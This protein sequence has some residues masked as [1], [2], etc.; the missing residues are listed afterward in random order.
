MNVDIDKKIDNWKEQVLDLT[1][2]N[3]MVDFSAT[4]TKSLPTKQTEWK[5]VADQ[6]ATGN[7]LYVWRPNDEEFQSELDSTDE[8][9][10][11][12]IEDTE[13]ADAQPSTGRTD[14]EASYPNSDLI[15]IRNPKET[16]NSLYNISLNQRK[17]LQEKGV[18]SLY[19]ALGMLEWFSVDY[20]DT[21]L[22]SPVFLV[23]VS[24]ERE[25]ISNPNRHDYKITS[26]DEV[27]INPALR[28]KLKTE[29]GLVL[30]ADTTVELTDLE[31]SFEDIEDLIEGRSRWSLANEVILGIFDFAKLSLYNDLE[32]QR[33]TIKS[34][35]IIRA[36]NGDTSDLNAD[37]SSVP[38]AEELDTTV[39]PIDTFQV[40]EADSSQQEA[41]EAAKQ[42]VSF[43]LQGPPGTGK[44]QTIAN[45]IAEKLAD[46][47]QV[48]FVSEKQAALEVVQNRLGDAGLARFCLPAHGKHASK[49]DVLRALGEELNAPQIKESST[50]P[51][52]LGK[53]RKRR[54]ELNEYG[55]VL[56]RK[57]GGIETSA[58][59]AH[60]IV[61]NLNDVQT[62]SWS[63]SDPL[64]IST[65]EL[66]T[67]IDT[68]D[69]LAQYDTQFR[70]HSS[71]PWS[72]TT[73]DRWRIDT[74]DKMRESL[75]NQLEILDRI[76]SFCE[77]AE[78]KLRITITSLQEFKDTIELLE[79]L[80]SR[81]DIQWTEELFATKFYQNESRLQDFADTSQE[82]ATL[83]EE[84]DKNYE[85][86]VY[87]EDGQELHSAVAAY[88]L[89]R[90]VRPSYWQL[91]K[92]IGAHTVGSYSPSA[93]DLQ[94]DMQQLMVIQQRKDEIDELQDLTR[95]FRQLYEG[96]ETNWELVLEVRE[97]ID[98]LLSESLL[99]EGQV[100]RILQDD[101]TDTAQLL[102]EARSLNQ[103]WKQ[104][105]AFFE[106][107]VDRTSLTTS[108]GEALD[109]ADFDSFSSKLHA[110]ENRVPELQQW[111][112]FS[113][114][115]DSATETIV[116]DYIESALEGDID[117]SYLV[118]GFRKKFY[119]DFLNA[120]YDQ[121]SLSHFNSSQHEK[122]LEQFRQLDKE[123]Q[124]LAKVEIQHR[125]TQRRPTIDL[126]HASSSE[127]VVLR[128]EIEKQ[129]RRMPL[130]ELFSEAGNMITR[131]KP[132]FMM[133]PLSVA[134]HL[135]TDS[136]DF[137]VVIF[138]EASQIMPQDA[139]SS[140]IRAKQ[141]VV[142]G[143][144]KQLPPTQFF[145]GDTETDSDVRDDLESILDE[146]AAVLP[147]KHLRWHYRSR[148]DELIT[149]SNQR[150][151]SGRLN[152]FPENDPDVPTGVDFEFVEDGIYDRGGSRQNQPEAR[153]IVDYIRQFAKE[154][155]SRS[156]GVVAFSEAQERA[157]RDLIEE[158]RRDDPVL[159]SF[160]DE[161][162]ALEG[163][164]IKNL[165]A[166]QGDERDV[167]LFSVGYGPDQSGKI[168]MNFGPLN[169]DGG[170]RRLNVAITRARERVIVFS[171]LQPGDIDTTRTE[172][173][174][175]RDFKAY[176]EYAK[177][178]KRALLE[179]RQ[180]TE[181]LNF[182]SSFEESVYTALEE[183]GYDVV[184]QVRSSG[185]S[186][187]LAIKHPE[188]PGKYILGIECDGAAYHSSKTARDRDRTRQLIL[189][190]LGWTIHR[191]WSP[192]WASNREQVLQS[193]ADKVSKLRETGRITEE[194]PV[195]APVK[196]EEA[197]PVES[198][199]QDGG[200]PLF[201]EYSAP[202]VQTY[203]DRDFDDIPRRTLGNDLVDIVEK[204]GPIAN[205]DAYLH[206]VS[207]WQFARVGKRMR[208]QLDQIRSRYE[209]QQL[210]HENGFLWAN[211]L[212]EVPVR[213]NTAIDKRSVDEIPHEELAKG[214]Y[215]LLE[216]GIA[217]SRDDL[218]LETARKFG[219]TR[220]GEKIQARLNDAIDY[221]V[222]IGA[223]EESSKVSA[224]GVDIDSFILRT[225]YE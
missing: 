174:G 217:M 205:D 102:S 13:E 133:S 85:Q 220:R 65:E 61:A 125:V 19:L 190:D 14:T 163:F 46:G 147:E 113:Q 185:Y 170:E 48:L 214:A 120:I 84:L 152:T 146:A 196:Q 199:E 82:I 159:D 223:V 150:Y 187:D 135:R 132:C 126:E 12:E 118:D 206:L 109:S 122:A 142:A 179:E 86:S 1:R 66:E 197:E 204:Y 162:D 77:Q 74:A 104:A 33:S 149:F 177:K 17:H 10:L 203:R 90:Y 79:R 99:T 56:L 95:F 157:I 45:I 96:T 57:Y 6:L 184:T 24:L 221:L 30:P 87:S 165:E 154:Y 178:G 193:I 137:D 97:W 9:S 40:L 189:E 93:A 209:G 53:L 207:Q 106:D 34:N 186:I 55:E 128:R 119:T 117:P 4:K 26:E 198:L 211:H 168:T 164:F 169:N 58:Y 91:K 153:R 180:A 83:R 103:Q 145:Q 173:R 8:T 167:M 44:S 136:I 78:S 60:G 151:Y 160:V 208:R 16:E 175:V 25:T 212:D 47:E 155:S 139:V 64:A 32:E 143:D 201:E 105:S 11:N 100:V 124:E 188:K 68:L 158:R 39:D 54:E 202:K 215:I 50:R 69:D 23:S 176:L 123:Q 183:Q 131:L 110:L 111:V 52:Q 216:N 161:S 43:V 49:D 218:V 156:L 59:E 181:T 15:S 41:I 116:E 115:L 140:I 63:I 200:T 144:T 70:N 101:T 31:A 2:R 72:H 5:A 166:V 35:P 76:V 7:E 51:Q 194:P 192:D 18:D 107:V 182:D 224:C 171:S 81:P 172:A 88:G 129:Q 38:A 80:D 98:T 28:K 21:K 134:Q 219:W 27:I 73:L 141:V 29:F 108:G 114:L 42:G 94:E 71:H 112:Q 22:R 67:A 36:L 75:K 62:P 191:I 92:Q 225:I 89:T 195:D 121:T 210:V 37:A 3:N 138:D 222:E 213:V 127:Q 20:S 130:R 148:T